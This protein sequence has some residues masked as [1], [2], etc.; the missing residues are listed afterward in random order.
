MGQS[1][2]LIKKLIDQSRNN[3]WNELPEVSSEK[4]DQLSSNYV[5]IIRF[6]NN[7]NALQVIIYPHKGYN[8]SIIKDLKPIARN[9]VELNLSGLPIGDQELDIVI[10]CI[11]LEKLN[12]SNTPV[13]EESIG[14]LTRLKKLKVIKIYNTNLSDDVLGLISELSDLSSLYVYNTAITD[15]GINKFRETNKD[16]LIIKSSEEAKGFMSVLP[17]PKVEPDKYFFIEPIKIKLNH[18]LEG[19]DLFYTT[20]G[21]IPDEMSK[22]ARDSLEIEKS[23]HLKY[24]ASKEGW[25]SSQIDSMRLFKTMVK[26][27]ACKLTNEPDPK[28]PGRGKHL[29][30]DLEKGP[31]NLSDSAW[32]A[33]TEENFILKC[34][35]KE[36]K[37]ISSVVISSMVHTDSYLFPPES[38]VVRGGMEKSSMKVLG[39]LVPGKLEER[40]NRYI[41]FY[42]CQ[43]DPA[44]VRFIEITV[45]PLQKIPMWHQGKSKK[46]W[47]FIDEVAFLE[48]PSTPF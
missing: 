21:S 12:I 39:R 25:E 2:E 4:L 10:M 26:P 48:K 27:D 45:Q 34:E 13:K 7:S 1:Y 37:T 46:G 36:E 3:K 8:N 17:S 16:V 44:T 43:F 6:F 19:I 14:K 23:T 15:T 31:T 32:M 9:I 35:W 18:P 47:F 28:Y 22:N 33:F 30:F 5:R 41:D 40:S 20:D 29:L 24:Y 11:N 38:I 42:E